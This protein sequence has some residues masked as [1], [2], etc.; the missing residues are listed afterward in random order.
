MTRTAMM[1]LLGAALATLARPSFGQ[2]APN[3]R[4]FKLADG[5]AESACVSVTVSAQGKVVARHL[6]STAASKLDGYTVTMVPAPEGTVR[7]YESPGGQLWTFARGAIEEYK[8]GSWETHPIAEIPGTS[9]GSSPSSPLALSPVRQGLVLCLMP[10]RLLEFDFSITGN[11]QAILMRR[12]EQTRLEK[13][14]SMAA[15]RDGGLWITG[16]RG[17]AKLPGP[18]RNLKPDTLWQEHLPSAHLQIQ[19]LQEPHEDLAGG[20]VAVAESATNYERVMAY[21]DGQSWGA[22]SSGGRRIRHAWRSADGR[23]WASTINSL[24]HSEGDSPD[25]VEDEDLSARQYFDAAVEPGG[26]FWLATSDGLYRFTPLI[27]RSPNW[28]TRMA[29]PIQCLA[30]DSQ[31]NV[32]FVSSGGLHVVEQG[33]HREYSLANTSAQNQPASLRLFPLKNGNLLLGGEEQLLEFHPASGRFRTIQARTDGRQRKVLGQLKDGKVGLQGWA[34]GA[35]SGSVL[36]GFDGSE[37]APLPCPAPGAAIGKD[38]SALFEEPNGDFWLGTG[39]GTAWYHEKKWRFFNAA[40]KTGPEAP[41]AFAEL[42]DGKMWCATSDKIWQFDGRDWSEVRRGFDQITCLLRAHRDGSVW[43][44]SQGGLHRYYEGAWIENGLEEGLPSSSIRALCEDQRGR[45]LAGTAHGLSHYD[46]EADREPPETQLRRLPE[47]DTKILAGGTITLLFSGQ[48]KWKQ[49]PRERLLYSHR[50]DD[51]DWS[52][53]QA[54]SPVTFSDLA[55]G[56]HYLQVRSMDRNGNR[57]SKPAQLVLA[58]VLPWY[59]ETRLVVISLA[60]AAVALFFAG[61]AFNRHRQLARSYAEVEKKVAQRTQELELASRQLLHSQKM[62]ALGTLAAGIAHDFNNILSIIKGSAQIM[63]EN[64]DNS[65][66]LRTRLDRIKTVVEQGAGIVKAM[67]GFSRD[68]DQQLTACDLNLVVEDTIKLLGDRF[69]REVQV[70]F[71]P[72][73]ALPDV[74]CA[75]D[76][77]QQILLNFIFNAAESMDRQKRIILETKRLEK[78]ESGLVLPPAQATAYAAISIQDFG[79][80]IPSENMPLI[81]DPFFTTKARSDRRGTGLGL[82]MVYELAKKLEAGLA[83]ES[84]VDRGSTFTLMLPVRGTTVKSK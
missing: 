7:V 79:C 2:R 4:V 83:V 78:L 84:I 9:G 38:W 28:R 34:D 52:A 64:L 62:N 29:S 68:S 49:T 70:K 44:A 76:L 56:K 75:K 19:N 3:W 45:L 61:L 8:E 5:L 57:E 23:W 37:F 12:A 82:S 13:F 24:Y 22:W 74:A 20:I 77:V 66:K 40:D 1:A 55:A 17:L 67:L 69:L 6:S 53:F 43:V 58:V 30:V 42:A 26:A 50:L 31:D 72:D 71:L 21:F 15:A 81:F 18:L 33:R 14:T 25:L 80:G 32:W 60:G 63:E 73:R 10:D 35:A 16:A 48:D 11:P 36:E 39:H 47:I 46:P 65:Q 27:W 54:A 41:V 59:Q 51:H